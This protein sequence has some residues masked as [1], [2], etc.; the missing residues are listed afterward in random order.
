[1]YAIDVSREGRLHVKHMAVIYLIVSALVPSAF[2]RFI[3]ISF[4]HFIFLPVMF[5]A[6]IV[7]MHSKN[8]CIRENAVTVSI[9][10]FL[11]YCLLHIA[12]VICGD[13]EFSRWF[14]Y[15][16][17]FLGLFAF[18]IAVPKVVDEQSLR[19][20]LLSLILASTVVVLVV[21]ITQLVTPSTRFVR[22][23]IFGPK[24]SSLYT[25]KLYVFVTV[26]LVGCWIFNSRIVPPPLLYP[27]LCL[28]LLRLVIDLRKAPVAAVLLGLLC[29]I[30]LT[31]VARL[32]QRRRK[33]SLPMKCKGKMFA[34]SLAALCA[35]AGLAVLFFHGLS[36]YGSAFYDLS[37]GPGALLKGYAW[38]FSFEQFE[39]FGGN[40]LIDYHAALTDP[41]WNP[42]LGAGLGTEFNLVHANRI[43]SL[44]VFILAHMGITGL[45]LFFMIIA[46]TVWT[47]FHAAIRSNNLGT[48]GI[49]IALTSAFVSYAALFTFSVRGT[50]F[51]AMIIFSIAGG[52]VANYLAN[53][54]RDQ[55][56]HS[57]GK[58]GA[59]VFAS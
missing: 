40:R 27:A 8:L 43:H 47:G 13:V 7:W 58:A 45:F 36:L 28:H 11:L 26:V 42:V 38:R 34:V 37:S 19:R 49:C 15:A 31:A 23:G 9:Q 25:S 1:M 30:G 56:A 6:L 12:F 20:I 33:G 18:F 35:L 22:F 55:V 14:R 10:L 53:T 44:Y 2:F 52:I 16:S 24:H 41:R 54:K 3:S 17:V 4:A 51:D 32:F 50:D 46:A 21:L 59:T 5:M 48:F 57:L 29:I 39:R